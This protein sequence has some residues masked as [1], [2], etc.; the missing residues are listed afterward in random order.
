M[1]RHVPGY[2]VFAFCK[3]CLLCSCDYSTILPGGSRSPDSCTPTSYCIANGFILLKYM[4][5]FTCSA[6]HLF[7][8]QSLIFP[9]LCMVNSAVLENRQ[10]QCCANVLYSCMLQQSYRLQARYASRK[11]RSQ[12]HIHG[13][14]KHEIAEVCYVFCVRTVFAVWRMQNAKR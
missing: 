9:A 12:D 7:V 14:R 8:K 5:R 13:T 3:P 4:S 2:T 1:P 11:A 10:C 6:Q